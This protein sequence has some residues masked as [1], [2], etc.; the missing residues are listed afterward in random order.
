MTD[1]I[2]QQSSSNNSHLFGSE[3][4]HARMFQ[5]ITGFN[6]SQIVHAA[7][8]F[9]LSEHLAQGPL[10]AEQIAEAGALNVD[11]TLR[12]LRACASMGLVTYDGSSKF[13]ATPLLNTL[14][15]A[16]PNSLRGIALAQPAP[17]HW[18]PWGHLKEA[19]KTGECQAES[20]LGCDVWG[21][22]ADKPA[23]A[24]VFMQ[25]MNRVSSEV[26]REAA[27]LLDTQSVHLAVDIGG[28][29]GTLVLALL[30]EN[31]TMRGVVFDLPHV[32][33]GAI[34][35]AHAHG[36]QN[37]LSAVSGDFFASVPP[38]DLYLLKWIMHDWGDDACIAILKNCRREIYPGGRIVLVELL[39]GEVG[40]A[41]FGPM[42]DLTMLVTL[43][44]RERTLD[45]YKA[46]LSTAGFRF[47]RITPTSTPFSLIEANAI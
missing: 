41:G 45:E 29:S 37:R 10:T 28:A 12:F 4:N 23:E 26:S 17:M 19:I 47:S 5:I 35:A 24:E 2:N 7:A 38:S 44:G 11:A 39:M 21:Y 32:V 14:N 46:L 34:K 9:S 18:L 36:L 15:E 42:V 8:A 6:A 16:D 22:L 1:V 27:R 30:K 3:N 40:V 33:P 31:P 20:T 13:A 25:S 43:G